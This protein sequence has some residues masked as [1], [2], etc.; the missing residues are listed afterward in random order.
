MRASPPG[1]LCGRRVVAAGL[2]AAMGGLAL[3]LFLRTLIATTPTR[4][5]DGSQFWGTVLLGVSGL[6]AGMAV[7]AV[8]Q[9][10]SANPDPAYRKRTAGS[11]R[12]GP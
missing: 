4:L 12:P 8:R 1:P 2:V 6:I 3:A 10:Q 9:L 5:S 11:R 7:E